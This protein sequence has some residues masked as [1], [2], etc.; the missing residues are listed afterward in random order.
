MSNLPEARKDVELEDVK[1]QS[2]VSEAV[3]N[4]IGASLNFINR[5]QYDDHS[6]HLNGP[7]HFGEGSTGSDGIFTFM[8]DAEVVGFSYYNGKTGTSG[9]TE[10]DIHWL[11]GGATDNGTIFSIKPRID[12]TASNDTYA[13]Y[14]ELDSATLSLP[15]GFTLATLSKT[16]FDA[17]DAI[18]LDLDSAM[19]GANNFQFT[20]FYRPR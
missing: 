16:Q 12:T 20:F 9:F 13:S 2:S 8:F 19:I 5:R 17:G 11:S 18:R 3:G 15:T 10:I 14:R 6:F 7:Y 4:K 1:F